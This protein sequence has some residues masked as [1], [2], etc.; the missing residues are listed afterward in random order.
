MKQSAETLLEIFIDE[1]EKLKKLILKQHEQNGALNKMLSSATSY[2]VKTDRLE[3][4]IKFWNELF[5]KQKAQILE[6]QK[7]EVKRYKKEE[8]KT[9]K[10][11][12]MI[13]LL[14]LIN[15]IYLIWD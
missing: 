1:N 15:L 7:N 3:E 12:I 10:L 6:L 4:V 13:I 14:L 9:F 5:N 11:L 8:S 2:E